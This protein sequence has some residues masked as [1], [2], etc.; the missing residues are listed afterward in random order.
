MAEPWQSTPPAGG[1]PRSA[2]RSAC[3]DED[4]IVMREWWAS[5][6]HGCGHDWSAA[7]LIVVEH[8]AA[9]A[10]DEPLLIPLGHGI[11]KRLAVLLPAR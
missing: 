1:W 10:Q 9:S 2:S 6:G 4:D 5:K 11:P 8:G 7:H 3:Q